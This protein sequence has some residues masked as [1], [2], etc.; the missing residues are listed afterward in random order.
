M[1]I[2]DNIALRVILQITG[3]IF[4]ILGI[5][6]LLLPVIPGGIFLIIA[7][8]CFIRSSEKMYQALLNHKF[9]GRFV[10]DYAENGVITPKLKFVALLTLI[11]PVVSSIFLYTF[12]N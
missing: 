7:A 3:A 12:K 6:G 1:K 5:M 8:A 10:K 4:F 11:M 9:L 2:V